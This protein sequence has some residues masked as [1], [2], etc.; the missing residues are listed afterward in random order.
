MGEGTSQFLFVQKLGVPADELAI[1]LKQLGYVT[2]HD[3]VHTWRNGVCV[4]L[5]E[6]L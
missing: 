5:E 2:Q 3:P 1:E 6:S 4:L